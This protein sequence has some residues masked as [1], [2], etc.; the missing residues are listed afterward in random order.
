MHTDHD[1]VVTV[2]DELNGN[3]T[4]M[5]LDEVVKRITAR[6]LPDSFEA[7]AVKALAVA[8]RTSVVKRLKVFDGVGCEKYKGADI[9]TGMKGCSDIT[10]LDLLKKAIGDGFESINYRVCTAVDDTSGLIATCGGRPIAAEYH[11]TCGG[12]TE[13]SEDV[14]GNRVM[15]FRK[16]LCKYCSNS[17]LWENMV[18][19]TM[20][21]FEDKLKVKTVKDSSIWGPELE[22]VIEEIER[23]ETGRVRKVKIGGKY[24]TGGEVKSMLGLSSSR[25]G[26]DPLVLRFRVRGEGSGLGMCLYGANNM[27]KEGRIYTDILKYYYT[28]INI[29]NIEI[30]GDE[31]PLKGKTF[32]IDP[33][34]GGE[35]GDDEKGLT[36]LREKDVNLYIAKKL[37]ENLEMSGAIV[38]LTRSEDVNMPMPKR[39]ELI[40]SIRPNFVISI[41]QNSFFAPKVSGTEIYFY[42]GDYEGE[43]MGKLILENIVKCLNNVNRGSRNADFSIL[44]ESKVS[45]IVVECM[46]ITNPDEEGQLREDGVKDKIARSIYRGIMDYYGM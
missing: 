39:M 30:A 3:I 28:N 13:N 44:R 18:D 45:A 15:Y 14:L 46:Y 16:V 17:P 23:D 6:E 35:N 11:L 27:A 8:I 40:N 43:K 4:R 24:F 12:G 41:H 19:I 32:I 29:E 9:C 22:G 38:K 5:K 34:H 26:W 7:E 2:F 10:N 21:D 37:A 20:K 25:F 33:G 42:R 31:V 1:I 36:G